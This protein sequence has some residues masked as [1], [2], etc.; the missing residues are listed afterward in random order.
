MPGRSSRPLSIPFAY[1]GKPFLIAK[2]IDKGLELRPGI[3]AQ[4]CAV[5]DHLQRLTL[6][7][8][9]FRQIVA[10]QAT[11]SNSFFHFIHELRYVIHSGA[12]HDYDEL[13]PGIS[14]RDDWGNPTTFAN[15]FDAD[16]IRIYVTALPK[17]TYRCENVVGQL[18]DAGLTPVA[19]GFP[20]AP[21]VK[22][23]VRDAVIGIPTIDGIPPGL[24]A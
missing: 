10:A 16:L 15:C 7:F 4:S 6:E 3:V 13:D 18:R 20:G 2:G 19:S 9:R 24:R 12:R 1:V 17:E 8:K 14:C 5:G 21:F 23:Q 11:H 22:R